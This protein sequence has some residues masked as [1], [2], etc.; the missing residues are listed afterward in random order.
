VLALEWPT[1]VFSIV[2]CALE[3]LRAVP[4]PVL[5]NVCYLLVLLLAQQAPVW[6]AADVV[7]VLVL[8]GPS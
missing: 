3:A 5:W 8:A 4:Q 6:A 7:Y 1:L 2:C